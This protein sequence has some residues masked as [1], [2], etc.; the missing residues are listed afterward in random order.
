[1]VEKNEGNQKREP[2]IP[3]SKMVEELIDTIGE[4]MTV[5]IIFSDSENDQAPIDVSLVSKLKMGK[6]E[7]TPTQ[8]ER[9]KVAYLVIQ[10]LKITESPEMIKAWFM[11]S[12]PL[13][14]DK[15]PVLEIASNPEGVIRAAKAFQAE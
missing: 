12:D 1:M 4:G 3:V 5:L 9:L 2:E 15:A 8:E 14:E 10:M 11:G 7:I 13:L 6:S